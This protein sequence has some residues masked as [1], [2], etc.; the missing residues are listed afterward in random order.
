[1]TTTD[2]A[3]RSTA[4]FGADPGP[5]S[6]LYS[7]LIGATSLVVLLQ[8]LWAGLF[9]R[10]GKDYSTGWVEVHSVGADVAIVLALVATIM[11]FVRLRPRRDLLVGTGALL[12]LLVLEAVIGGLIGDHG[13]LT[14]VHFPLGMA[15]M[16]LAVWL[17]LRARRATA[18]A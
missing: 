7:A 1:M 9:V 6:T 8:A 11:A 4:A 14:A 5:R 16:A 15:L 13:G 18:A 10:E 12:V 2:P 3:A 17:P